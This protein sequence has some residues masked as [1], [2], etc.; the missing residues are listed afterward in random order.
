VQIRNNICV[1]NTPIADAEQAGGSWRQSEMRT[2]FARVR[3]AS[4]LNVRKSL[5]STI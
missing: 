1:W 5:L 3:A 2:T 4:F